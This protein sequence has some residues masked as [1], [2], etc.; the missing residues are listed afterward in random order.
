[1]FPAFVPSLARE[2]LNRLIQQN[3]PRFPDTHRTQHGPYNRKNDETTYA[4]PSNHSQNTPFWFTQVWT[5]HHFAG[6]VTESQVSGVG[7]ADQYF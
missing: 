7:H 3:L 1:M 4:E 2:S 6:T 5:V